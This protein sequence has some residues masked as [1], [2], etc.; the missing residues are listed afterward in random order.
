MIPVTFFSFVVLVVM[1]IG[2]AYKVELVTLFCHSHHQS[3][4]WFGQ[5]TS[6]FDDHSP[7]DNQFSRL[8]L[9]S[10]K[11]CLRYSSLSSSSEPY[12]ACLPFPQPIEN[13]A[14]SPWSGSNTGELHKNKIEGCFEKECNASFWRILHPV[15][16]LRAAGPYT[17]IHPHF[18]KDYGYFKWFG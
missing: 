6:Y 8:D 4:Q 13:I 16:G 9:F 3:L 10:S 7:L 17:D 18:P 5:L 2:E 12:K 15:I 14:A 1:M 11:L